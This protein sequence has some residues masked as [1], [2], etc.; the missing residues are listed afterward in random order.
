MTPAV[1]GL[2][3]LALCWIAARRPAWLVPAA[4]VCAPFEAAAVVSAGGT[5]V[6][7]YYFALLLIAVRIGFVRTTVPTLLGRTPRQRTAMAWMAAT[8]AVAVAGAMVLPRVFA[9]W[10]VLSPRLDAD[11]AAPLSF[12]A[13]NVAQAAYLLLNA[14]LLWYAAQ[15]AGDGA[16]T[17]RVIVATR[18]AGIVVLGLACYQFVAASAGLPYPE[19]VLYSSPG[20]VIQAGT[21]VMG[22]PR[23][24]GPFTEPAAMAVFLV[25][26]LMFLAA[27]PPSFSR[28]W[29]V[30]RA[31]LV[32]LS[33]VVLVL[34]T[35]STA[36]VGL[37]GAAAWAV[38]RYVAWPLIARQPL[39]RWAVG[40]LATVA[41]VAGGTYLASPTLQE[42]VRH[43]VFEKDDSSSYDERHG[44]DQFST[45]L[46]VRTWGLGVGLGS[47]RGSSFGPS[48]L[49][50]AGVYGTAALA[51]TML[52]LLRPAAIGGSSRRWH[53]PLAAG[54]L[55]VVGTKLVSSPDL[56]TP[57]MWTM[58]AGLMCAHGAAD[59]EAAAPDVVPAAAEFA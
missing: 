35:S 34:S 30:A 45:E 5:G 42:M 44:A 23:L 26:Y 57:A 21:L 31:G 39:E 43:M 55:G 13:G 25:G 16:G 18:A 49:S 59:L 33:I 53:G 6:S 58:M 17:R 20:Y 51:G 46:A 36:F 7:P 4:A 22:W 32:V 2:W 37:A 24:C 3:A 27:E 8:A 29:T 19:D 10:A 38:A 52:A 1:L 9:G 41:V 56:V 15:T 14:G 48:V 28:G 47:N 11:A 40:S 54:L 50:T 12:S